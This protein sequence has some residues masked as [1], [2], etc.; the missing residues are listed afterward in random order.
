MKK[1]LI[2]LLLVLTIVL[3]ACASA[4]ESAPTQEP[5]AEEAAA[6]ESP[7]DETAT[8]TEEQKPMTDAEN[9]C[10]PF[11]IMEQSLVT[12]FPNL[13]PVS[14]DDWVV[15]P[16]DAT[17]TLLEYSELQCPYCAQLEPSMVAI[18][19]MHPD[20]VR[21]VFRHRPFPE[22]FHDKSILAA[23]A[24]EA[25]GKQGRFSE[26]KNFMFERQYQDPNDAAQTA[27]ADDEFWAGIAPDDFDE[28][29]AERVP[30]LGIDAE[31][32][33]KDMVSDE[34]VQKIQ[35]KMAEADSLGIQ[36]TPTLFINGYPW[37]AQ[38]RGVDIFS[39]FTRLILKQDLEY[40]SCP[41]D[42]LDDEKSYSATI[43]TTQGDIQV[44]LFADKAPYA[45]NSF[46]F[47]A[48]EGWYD[49]LPLISTDDLILSG[50]PTDTGYGGPGYVYLDETNDDFN[51]NQP[52]MLAI[53]NRLGPGMNGSTFFINKNELPGFENLTIFGKVVE[54][55]DVVE[56]I[57]LRQNIME[58]VGD[59][60]LSVT[61]NEE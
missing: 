56:K 9:P 52:G 15:G 28:W 22:S 4:A 47:L 5:T 14:D 17:V 48:R 54:G 36:G 43:S 19:E 7:Q 61:I 20:D 42:Q 49:N 53:Y 40:S 23:Q 58:P 27:L 59:R 10:L 34:I 38:Q 21:I 33:L 51:F 12:P 30:D 13:P 37:P 3:G 25:A 46:V 41:I 39:I 18:Q 35:E 32:F 50:D 60:V 55:M 45:V 57:A 8:Q 6:P 16:P 11:S 24:L 44:E 1:N 31:Q 2:P 26:F 29:M